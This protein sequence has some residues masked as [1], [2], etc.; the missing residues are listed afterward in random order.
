MGHL[1][2]RG[3][4]DL[5]GLASSHSEKLSTG[6]RDDPCGEHGS[7]TGSTLYGALIRNETIGFPD[8]T[9]GNSG[10]RRWYCGDSSA[11]TA[12]APAPG[13][14]RAPF[15]RPRHGGDEQGRGPAAQRAVGSDPGTRG[16]VV[17]R[18][19]ASGEHFRVYLKE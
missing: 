17:E 1:R 13:P 16:D 4:N 12:P 8:E 15:R 9:D 10:H 7:V 19:I 3:S 6:R 14:A 2:K 5:T 11:A 18:R